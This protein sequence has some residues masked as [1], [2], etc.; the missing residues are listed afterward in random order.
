[1]A[2]YREILSRHIAFKNNTKLERLAEKYG[3]KIVWLSKFHCELNPIE[4][5]WCDSKQFVRKN[6][7]QYVNNFEKLVESSFEKFDEKDLD[8]K[9]WFRFWL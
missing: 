9:L 2:Q 4:E 6:N 1:L 8:I 5:L 7:D 3:V